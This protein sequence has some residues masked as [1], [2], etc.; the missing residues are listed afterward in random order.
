VWVDGQ[1]FLEL[2]VD[3]APRKLD[4]K[5]HAVAVYLR[6]YKQDQGLMVPHLQETVVQGVPKNEKVTIE[7]V[8]L[9]R[10]WMTPDLPMPSK[11]PV[12]LWLRAEWLR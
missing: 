1:S 4:G 12:G 9:N 5:V 11:N 8:T 7:S 6:D 2:K 3:G 10:R